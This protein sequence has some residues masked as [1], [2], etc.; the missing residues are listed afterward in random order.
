VTAWGEQTRRRVRRGSGLLVGAL[1]AV[2]AALGATGAA[3][4]SAH[5]QGPQGRTALYLVTLTGPGTA[6]ESGVHGV[7]TNG[8]PR[9]RAAQVLRQDLVLDQVG[10]PAPVYRWTT[11]LDGFAVRL[12]AVQAAVLASSSEVALVEPDA[13]RRLTGLDRRAGAGPSTRAVPGGGRDQ[14]IGFVDSG[15]WP[16]SAAFAESPGMRRQ[17][18]GFHGVCQTGEGWRRSLCDGK[19]VGARYFVRGFGRDRIAST[20]RLSPVDDDGHGTLS[21]SIA[22]GDGG[23]TVQVPGVPRRVTSGVA[24]RARVAV[25]KACWQAPDPADDGCSTADLVTAIDRATRDGVDVLDLPVAGPDRIDTVERAL[26]GAAESG[27][28]VVASAGNGR[29]PA[30]HPSPWVTT[31][32]AT[33]GNRS[34]GTATVVGGPRLVGAMSSGRQVGPVRLVLGRD[35]A[36]PGRSPHDAAR[37]LPGSLD[38]GRAAGRVVVCRRGEI[39]RVDKSAAVAQADGVGMVLVNTAPGS[40]DADF[41]SVP[42]VHLDAR[43]GRTLVAW[44]RSHPRARVRLAPAGVARPRP[45]VPAWSRAGDPHGPLLKPDLLAPGA[46]VLGAVPP[47]ERGLRWDL[48]SGTSAATASVS[49]LAAA[50][51]AAPGWT[52]G[53][54]RSALATTA[55]AIPG[56]GPFRQGSGLAASR[57]AARPHLA[58]LPQPDSYRRWLDGLVAADA[59]DTPSVFLVPGT[60]SPTVVTRRVT[61]VSGRAM[62]FSSTATGFTHHQVVVTPAATR[63]AP[64]ESLTFRIHVYGVEQ[65]LP[66]SGSV[67]WTA[68]DDSTVRIPVV[69]VH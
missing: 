23:V 13:V 12:G 63:L 34:R 50:L 64:G 55:R 40:I 17:P 42:T 68:A 1:V 35:L 31:V 3:P 66:D 29:A 46:G 57:P 19:V 20:A 26:L 32:G 65:R 38:A 51:G 53:Q 54:V 15:L 41:H 44:I 69:I 62:Y 7:P 45:R 10:A 25:Y 56:A 30:A 24:P 22:A 49:G 14:V 52:P 43:G 18:P 9:S 33:T 39:G 11:A 8:A 61:N 27:T 5:V 59:L 37:C 16:H 58:Y 60:T 21:A 36:V 6:G 67:T 2:T 28:V 47:D 4:A 48:E